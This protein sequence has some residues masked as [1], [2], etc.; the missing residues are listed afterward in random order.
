M[1]AILVAYSVIGM[2][3]NGE[4]AADP[5]FATLVAC[6]RA[7]PAVIRQVHEIAARAAA[8]AGLTVVI[9]RARCVKQ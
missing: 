7:K 5:R 6:E 9:T 1:Y 2:P 3:I 4:Q 8:G